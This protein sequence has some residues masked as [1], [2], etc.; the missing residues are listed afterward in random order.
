MS[1]TPWQ[2]LKLTKIAVQNDNC[3][4]Y[5]ADKSDQNKNRDFFFSFSDVLKEN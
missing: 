3:A 2:F 4:D 5:Y 1:L